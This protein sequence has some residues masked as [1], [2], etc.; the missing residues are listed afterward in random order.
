MERQKETFLRHHT[1]IGY[2][3]MERTSE[4]HLSQPSCGVADFKNSEEN[5]GI[6]LCMHLY[7]ARCLVGLCLTQNQPPPSTTVIYVP[8]CQQDELVTSSLPNV[9]DFPLSNVGF[10]S[11]VLLMHHLHEHG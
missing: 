8:G 4:D 7:R 6:F 11:S 3:K 10:I 9:E 5:S 1:I 2:F